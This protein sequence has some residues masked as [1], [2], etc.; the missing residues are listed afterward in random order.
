MLDVLFT[1]GRIYTLVKEGSL[2]QAVGV[3]DGKIV[4]AGTD[5]EA[6]HLETKRSV[7]LAGA[8]MIPGMGDSHLHFYAY[9][10]TLVQVDLGGCCS[11]KEVM[12]KLAERASVIPK[13]QWIV[14]ANFDQ[15]KWNDSKDEL[16]T[17]REL[18][19]VTT[20]H[21]VAIKRVCLHVAVV[22]T[23]ALELA[24]LM[25]P[26]KYEVYEKQGLEFD[27]AGNPN[28]VLREGMI[29]FIDDVIP[30]SL[31]D[32]VL[33]NQMMAEQMQKMASVGITT[34]HTY[35]AKIWKYKEDV[36][37]YQDLQQKGQ[38]KQRVSIYTDALED[39][40]TCHF[41]SKEEKEDAFH[42]IQMSGYKL[43]CDG[44]LGSHGAALIEPY[45]DEPDNYGSVVMNEKQLEEKMSEAAS[46]G[47]QCAVHA[48]GDRALDMV[49]TAIEHVTEKIAVDPA[50]PFR[51][52]HVQM[53][54]ESLIRRMKKLPVI[55]DV[56]PTF[57]AT[58]RYWVL[59]RIGKERFEHAYAWRTYQEQGL[60][61]TGGSDAPV[62]S[63]D[64]LLGIY[65][66]LVHPNKKQRLS[67]YDAVCM[68]SK[69]I[70][71]ATGDDA[72]VGTIEAGK[73]ADFAVLDRDI[74]CVTP[75]QVRDTKVI[76][77][78]LAGEETWVRKEE[79]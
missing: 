73:F 61:M 27:T 35:A 52:I 38:L 66:C 20:D 53:A 71:C 24:G 77:T 76:R 55:L 7:D 4:F 3:K 60:T 59:D 16:P 6:E 62:E 10:K 79:K 34:M 39:L 74:F 30:D 25:D 26:K 13:G 5:K 29:H 32:S 33:R 57:L 67:V 37:I 11:K 70:A 17:R 31:D 9:C 56:Q 23:N 46:L 36:A 64:P 58:D 43:F 12:Q 8:T 63:F 14:G 47:I 54:N 19:Q 22:N 75:E 42:K 78:I 1:N 48:I 72:Y 41:P 40:K 65:N 49:L 15:S 44:S 50:H 21:P 69:N 51:L 68:Y 28:G 2:V 18:D 45:A